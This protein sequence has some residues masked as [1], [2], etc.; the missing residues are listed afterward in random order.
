MKKDTEYL[1]SELQ[2]QI[3]HTGAKLHLCPYRNDQDHP[4]GK[5]IVYGDSGTITLYAQNS[6]GEVRQVFSN[7]Y[8]LNADGA[9]VVGDYLRDWTLDRCRIPRNSDL[10]SDVGRALHGDR[11]QVG[12]SRDLNVSDRTVRRWA[13]GDEVPHGVY[14]DMLKLAQNRVSALSEII[15]RL[16]KHLNR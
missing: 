4:G 13:A 10:L 3:A 2:E 14:D 11:W 1:V 5:H 8:T 12:L 16:G 7:G 6:L 9:P 15:D